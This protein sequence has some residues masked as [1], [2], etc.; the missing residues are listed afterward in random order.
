MNAYWIKFVN[1][2][3]GCVE[4]EN[5]DEAKKIGVDLIKS[6]I[7]VCEILPYPAYPRINKVKNERG[8]SCPSFCY[9]PNKCKGHNSCRASRSCTE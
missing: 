8:Y 1:G 3:S 2:Y 5:E 9:Q 6:N 4:A 7:L